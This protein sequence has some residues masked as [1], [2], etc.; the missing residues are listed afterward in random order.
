MIK[1][2]IK[3]S[4]ILFLS[5]LIACSS[6]SYKK[7]RIVEIF[8]AVKIESDNYV[9]SRESTFNID[10]RHKYSIRQKA[11]YDKE[12]VIEKFILYKPEGIIAYSK[13]NIIQ[14]KRLLEYSGFPF[15]QKWF[16]VNKTLIDEKGN[17]I[18][19]IIKIDEFLLKLEIGRKVVFYKIK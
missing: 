5:N 1:H 8:N 19:G 9:F 17:K 2:S 7:Y 16:Y 13:E 14:D 18:D 4:I 11:I 15:I 3:F 6:V 12:G 10:R